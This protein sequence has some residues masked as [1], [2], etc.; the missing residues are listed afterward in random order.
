MSQPKTIRVERSLT[1]FVDTVKSLEELLQKLCQQIHDRDVYSSLGADRMKLFI[2]LEG[3]E[4]GRNGRISLFTIL[5]HEQ[6]KEVD[7]NYDTKDC[8]LQSRYVLDIK[9]LG[10]ATFSTVAPKPE[11][12]REVVDWIDGLSIY[13]PSITSSSDDRRPEGSRDGP[14]LRFGDVHTLKEILE[15]PDITKIFFDV[16]NDADALFAHFGIHLRG[17]LDLQLLENY[18][19]HHSP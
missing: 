8:M 7:D 15:C 6:R 9:T 16:R 5:V 1:Q 19:R 10:A 18:Q 12:V 13:A 14:G 11:P 17:T 2:D 3:I 4:L